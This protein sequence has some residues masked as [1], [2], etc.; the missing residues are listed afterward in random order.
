MNNLS[1]DIQVSKHKLFG[2][3]IA[4]RDHLTDIEY[5]VMNMLAEDSDIIETVKYIQKKLA[6]QN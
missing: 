3:L 1:E 4:N 5:M 6:E 2:Q